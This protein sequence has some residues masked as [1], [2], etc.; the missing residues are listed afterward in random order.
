MPAESQFT[1]SHDLMLGTLK[2]DARRVRFIAAAA[3]AYWIV[4]VGMMHIP[5]PREEEVLPHAPVPA[6][7]VV[8]V[9]AYFAFSFLLCWA[10]DERRRLKTAAAGKRLVTAAVVFFV[11]SI[12]GAFDELTQPWTG[13]DCNLADYL[14]DLVGAFLGVVAFWFMFRRSSLRTAAE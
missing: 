1:S 10:W 4:L 7:K 13:R 9:T 11:V 12:Y 3:L 14:G 2:P 5:L 6:D 8:H